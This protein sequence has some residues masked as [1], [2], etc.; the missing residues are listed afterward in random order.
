V[1]V[2]A[3]VRGE[4]PVRTLV[5][6]LIPLGSVTALIG[7]A[8]AFT[9]P[10]LS[11]FLTNTLH[12]DPVHT[13][14]FLFL[15]PLSTVLV[16]TLIGRLSDRVSSR[17]RWLLAGGSAAGTCGYLLFAVLPNYWVLLAVS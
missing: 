16:A 1:S 12:A 4:T 11:L 10:F 13:A 3:P 15:T 2:I 17:R 14:V 9:S 6:S 7:L 5:I 8:T